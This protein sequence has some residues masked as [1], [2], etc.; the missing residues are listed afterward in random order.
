[1]ETCIRSKGCPGD[2]KADD[3]VLETPPDL[4]SGILHGELSYSYLRSSTP[5]QDKIRNSSD[6]INQTDFWQRR[7][8]EAS[9]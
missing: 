5:V 1:M 7:K 4:L 9:E 2:E 3:E 6:I 8:K